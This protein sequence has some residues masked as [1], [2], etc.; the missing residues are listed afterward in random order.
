MKR[1]ERRRKQARNRTVNLVKAPLKPM[2]FYI[3]TL[4]EWKRLEEL[5]Y[6]KPEETHVIMAPPKIR[7]SFILHTP[8]Y[9]ELVEKLK[10]R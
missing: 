2:S 8:E 3:T 10:R 6:C 9:K 4:P 1:K 7:S 5:E